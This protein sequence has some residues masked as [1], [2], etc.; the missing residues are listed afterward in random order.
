MGPR[1][2]GRGRQAPT[3]STVRWCGGFNG[4]TARRPWK[5]PFRL[6]TTVSYTAS[7]GPRPGGRGRHGVTNAAT[8]TFC[9][10]FNGATARRPWKTTPSLCGSECQWSGFNGA[11]ARRPWKTETWPSRST[12]VTCFNGATARRPWKTTIR[13]TTTRGS[14]SFNG[15]TAR[16]PWKTRVGRG[17]IYRMERLQ[18]GHGPEAVEDKLKPATSTDA[19]CFNGATARRPWKTRSGE[20]SSKRLR[21][22]NGATARRPWKTGKVQ[23]NAEAYIAELQW[24]HGPEAVEDTGR[25]SGPQYSKCFNGAT[26]RRPWKTRLGKIWRTAAAGASMG[27]RPGGRGRPPLE[28]SSTPSS[29]PLQ[30][31]HG[32][33]AVEDIR[34]RVAVFLA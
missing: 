24:G 22:F 4:A 11:T 6:Q 15:A 23:Q 9:T 3:Q 33:E 21:R 8:T 26:A 17:C 7:M 20:E 10:G 13:R 31:G 16:R 28:E 32:P 5:T 2:G 1:P 27:P 29:P 34:L 19:Q 14:S 12:G 18:W 25:G 30:W